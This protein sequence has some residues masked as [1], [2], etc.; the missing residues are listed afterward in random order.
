MICYAF[1]FKFTW[2]LR[3]APASPLKKCSSSEDIELCK[4]EVIKTVHSD[5]FLL[6]LTMSSARARRKAEVLGRN[7]SVSAK[8]FLKNTN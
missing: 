2:S 8:K 5:S 3:Y 1:R 4:E 7:I 6:P